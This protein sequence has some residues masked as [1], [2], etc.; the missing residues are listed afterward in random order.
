MKQQKIYM[1]L[2]HDIYQETT[3]NIK[4]VEETGLIPI[5]GGVRQGD[6][7]FLMALKLGL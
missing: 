2:I 1:N 4:L 3:M 7:F 6:L 5:R